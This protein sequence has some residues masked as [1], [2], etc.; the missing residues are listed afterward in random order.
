LNNTLITL[1]AST[2]AADVTG[3][4]LASVVAALAV[5]VIPARRRQAKLEMQER[6]S[7]LRAKLSEA[8]RI[9]FDRVQQH[10][11]SRIEEAVAPY[12]R[13]V[14]AEREHWT[15]ARATL[16]SLRDRVG[17]FRDRLAA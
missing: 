6:V 17:T 11:R 4:L 9:E 8:L 2:A 5:F 16:E 1:A 3:I 15:E 14:R 7:T 13:F 10:G 12:S